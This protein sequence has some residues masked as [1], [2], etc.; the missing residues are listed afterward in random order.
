M[1]KL[2]ENSSVGCIINVSET[3]P[4]SSDSGFFNNITEVIERDNKCLY[5]FREAIGSVLFSYPDSPL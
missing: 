1:T 5:L 2:S 4:E 3:Q